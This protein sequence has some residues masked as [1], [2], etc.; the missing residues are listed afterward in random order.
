MARP[1]GPGLRGGG[2]LHLPRVWLPSWEAEGVPA[3]GSTTPAPAASPWRIGT[4]GRLPTLLAARPS[5]PVPTISDLSSWVSSLSRLFRSI[6][7]L[8]FLSPSLP[9]SFSAF[10]SFFFFFFCLLFCVPRQPI[11]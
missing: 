6:P 1:L 7:C 9:P 2:S 11:E 10:F 5:P 3:S 8:F 4:R